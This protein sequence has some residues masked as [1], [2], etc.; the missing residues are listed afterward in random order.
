MYICCFLWDADKSTVAILNF[1]LN[2]KK[3]VKV[4]WS[5]C[6]KLDFL[7]Y[8]F[9]LFISS[10]CFIIKLRNVKYE[11]SDVKFRTFYNFGQ[12]RIGKIRI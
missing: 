12:L 6:K 8:S 9:F 11:C 2:N 5:R 3:N 7:I 10:K 4:L 1:P